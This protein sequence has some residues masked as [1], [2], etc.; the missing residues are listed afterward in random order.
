MPDHVFSG[1]FGI[2]L[3]EP[4]F[5]TRAPEY[6]RIKDI[7]IMNNI[8]EIPAFPPRNDRL[9]RSEPSMGGYRPLRPETQGEITIFLPQPVD[10]AKVVISNLLEET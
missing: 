1:G 5:R 2:A 7:E 9:S 4:V 8:R 6:I 3:P 10:G